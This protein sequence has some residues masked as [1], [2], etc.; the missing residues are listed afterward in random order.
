MAEVQSIAQYT[1]MHL[2]KK[3]KMLTCNNINSKNKDVHIAP[4]E[5]NIPYDEWC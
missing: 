2:M 5:K 1:M 3:I 4:I